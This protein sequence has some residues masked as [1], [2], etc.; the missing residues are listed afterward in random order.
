MKL[1]LSANL[2][3]INQ[4]SKYQ[5]IN[6]KLSKAASDSRPESYNIYENSIKIGEIIE[7]GKDWNEREKWVLNEKNVYSSIEELHEAQNSSGVSLGLVRLK[8][9]TRIHIESKSESD[10]EQALK[11]KETIMR[12]LDMFED[13]KDLEI[14]PVRFL[15]H[16]RCEGH[17][18]NGHVMSILDWEFAQLYR[19]VR[20]G[21]DWKIKIE[22]KIKDICGSDRDTYL[23]LGNMAKRQ[24]IFCILGFFYPPKN[25]QIYL[26]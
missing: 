26:F 7:P 12:Q 24:H 22:K 13:K 19:N 4:F 18:C 11:K 2:V 23:I 9:L 14:L 10:I 20:N 1:E 15:M 5:W 17:E 8:E 3:G 16:F 25:R 21:K 6:V